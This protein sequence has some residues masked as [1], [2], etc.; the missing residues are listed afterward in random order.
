[1]TLDIKIK[2]AGGGNEQTFICT[3]W[4]YKLDRHVKMYAPVSLLT[5]A[6]LTESFGLDFGRQTEVF[7]IYF[8]LQSYAAFNAVRLKV[9]GGWWT[10]RPAYL[11]F[12]GTS[13]KGQ[14]NMFTVESDMERSP[15][16][17]NIL[18]TIEFVVGAFIKI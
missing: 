2:D 8:R 17:T 6:S 10:S 14:V 7:T 18:G 3:R 9:K 4:T 11:W 15:E 16:D 13:H 1:M 5:G 12:G